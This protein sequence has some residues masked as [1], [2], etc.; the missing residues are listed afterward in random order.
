MTFSRLLGTVVTRRHHIIIINQMLEENLLVKN[1]FVPG[2][3]E[4]VERQR[5]SYERTIKRRT[6]VTV[7][8][9]VPHR[10]RCGSLTIPYPVESLVQPIFLC[11]LRTFH[12]LVRFVYKYQ[13]WA[14]RTVIQIIFC[15]LH[16]VGSCA[17][18]FNLY[19]TPSLTISLGV[20]EGTKLN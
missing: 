20:S 13:Y 16:W 2:S 3:P 17:Q 12:F 4:S 9:I 14:G 8:Y 7:L 15:T 1:I 5:E 18:L 11:D 10:C 6:C 19:L